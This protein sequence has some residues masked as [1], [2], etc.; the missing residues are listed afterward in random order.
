MTMAARSHD[1]IEELVAADALD[2]LDE[3]DRL[4][5]RREMATHGEHCLECE[6]LVAEYT[7]AAGRLAFG[8]EPVPM[9]PGAEDRLLETARSI[10][11]PS[12]LAPGTVASR[13]RPSSVLPDRPLLPQVP[14]QGDRPRLAA[15]RRRTDV[16]RWLSAA[17]VAAAIA[18]V[19]GFVGY[20]LAPN[21]A[22]VRTVAFP[23]KHGQR[24]AVVYSPGT[25]DAVVVGSNL[26]PPPDGKVYELWYRPGAGAGMRPAGTFIPDPSGAVVA[27]TK[28]GTSFDLLA[29][30]YE[31]PGGSPQPTS[32]PVFVEPV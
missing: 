5:L 22:G 8:L 15:I 9:S 24:L 32:Q 19:A 10:R 29:V 16:R 20:A 1:R 28:V 6:R 4:E 12:G 18:V 3:R 13:D 31:P 26:S 30:S 11:E 7:E 27:R 21:G 14:R 25:G 2:G 17:A 23:A